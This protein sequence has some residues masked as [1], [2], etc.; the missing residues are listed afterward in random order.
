MLHFRIIDFVFALLGFLVSLPVLLILLIVGFFDTGSPLFVQTRVGQNKK[1]F[2][3]IKLRTMTVGTANVATHLAS[4][5]SIT[6]YGAFLRKT[7]LDEI[8]QLINVLKGDMSLVGP[9]P[10]LFEQHD[11]IEARDKYQL[12]SFKPGITGLSQ[13]QGID[14]SQPELLAK[15]DSDMMA[16]LTLG[17][18]FKYLILT[19]KGN[20]QGDAIKRH[21]QNSAN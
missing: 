12:A 14:M 15:T 10:S 11:V 7:K 8:P 5:S 9:R 3:L 17:S 4:E 6:R 16:S 21:A 1:A 2:T 19:V 13:V 18:Y 20:G